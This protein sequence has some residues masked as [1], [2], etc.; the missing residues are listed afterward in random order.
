LIQK[1]YNIIFN[2]RKKKEKQPKQ[3]IYTTWAADDAMAQ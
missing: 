3:L 2:I 1:R